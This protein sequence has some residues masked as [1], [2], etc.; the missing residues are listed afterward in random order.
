MK[1]G[2]DLLDSYN[3]GGNYPSSICQSLMM[4]LLTYALV[5]LYGAGHYKKEMEKIY[6]NIIRNYH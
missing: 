4:D 2:L 3:Q 5:S 1:K 6:E